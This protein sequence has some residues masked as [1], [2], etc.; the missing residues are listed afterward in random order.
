MNIAITLTSINARDAQTAQFIIAQ[1]NARRAALVPPIAALPSGTA[2]ELR[3]SYEAHLASL[4]AAAHAS[5]GVQEAEA[6]GPNNAAI[7]AAFMGATPAQRT[8]ALAALTA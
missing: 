7:R 6:N 3:A 1:E 2:A 4:V 8:A 5:Y